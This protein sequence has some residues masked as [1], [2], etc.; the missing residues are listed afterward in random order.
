[1]RKLRSKPIY[2]LLLFTIIAFTVPMSANAITVTAGTIAIDN[3]HYWVTGWGQTYCL[4]D[5][6]DDSEGNTI[7]YAD[8]WLSKTAR[9]NI[10][11]RCEG[12]SD[13]SVSSEGE[14]STGVAN[15]CYHVEAT[16]KLAGTGATL[17][18]G[19]PTDKDHGCYQGEFSESA[20]K[21]RTYYGNTFFSNVDTHAKAWIMNDAGSAHAEG[22]Y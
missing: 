17:G 10:L 4:T 11:G 8:T 19:F 3:D 16:V 14:T 5:Y 12:S 1:M 20:Y 2:F 9:T 22:S 18:I 13:A 15:G 7:L 21:N 6:Q